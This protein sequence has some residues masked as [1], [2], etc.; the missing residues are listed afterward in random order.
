[1]FIQGSEGRLSVLVWLD[2]RI[3]FFALQV[4]EKNLCSS[5]IDRFRCCPLDKAALFIQA[6]KRYSNPWRMSE[7]RQRYLCAVTTLSIP[8]QQSAKEAGCFKVARSNG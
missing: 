7:K 1:M 3:A 5:T 8:L 4:N 2:R 6:Q